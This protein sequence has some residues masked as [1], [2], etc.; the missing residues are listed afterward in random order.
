MKGSIWIASGLIL[1]IALMLFLLQ[2]RLGMKADSV[3]TSDMR[4]SSETASAKPGSDQRNPLPEISGGQQGQQQRAS[5]LFQ[6]LLNAIAGN[7]GPR[8]G[9]ISLAL[10]DLLHKFPQSNPEI[11]RRI[12]KLIEDPSLSDDAKMTLVNLLSRTATTSSVETLLELSSA[13]L[14]GTLRRWIYAAIGDIGEYFWDNKHYPEIAPILSDAWTEARDPELLQALASAMAKVGIGRGVDQLFDAVLSQGST[15][16]QI[17]AS[18]NP[19]VQAALG[20][21]QRANSPDLIP[22][23]SERLTN[24]STSAETTLCTG[25]LVSIQNE[26]AARVLLEWAQ[27]AENSSAILARDVFARIWNADCLNYLNSAVQNA[28][29]K[30]SQVETAIL[31]ALRK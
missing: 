16:A 22:A 1:S 5:I 6:E 18:R 9:E 11:Y 19:L 25:I 17:L 31:S 26:N 7:D 2:T 8:A 27:N 20:A 15:M 21:L 24:S 23:I 14:N 28:Q 10:S 30:S 13:D 3:R 29:F 4:P 12:V